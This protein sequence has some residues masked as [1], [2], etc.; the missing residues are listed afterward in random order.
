MKSPFEDLTKLQINKL[1]DLLSV[2]Q[3]KY[4]RNEEILPTIK[5]ENIVC[6]IL[7]GFAQII[8]MEYNGDEILMENLYKNSV[9]GTNI[10]GTNNDNCEIIARDDTEVLVIDYD[11]L[12]N[13]KNL[14]HNYFNT[15]IR[16]LFDITNNKYKET[17]KR[18]RILEKKQIRDRLLEFFEI[19]YARNPLKTLL[20]PF[21]L[22]ELS[23]YIGVNRSAMFRELSHLKDDKLIEVHGRKIKLLYK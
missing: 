11:N 9:F 5:N 20:L 17:N 1:F 16:N 4:H 14:N 18:L 3:Y 22:K 6:I 19:N 7:E 10:S 15:F 21:S 2:H 8:Y 12:L 23:D 13:P